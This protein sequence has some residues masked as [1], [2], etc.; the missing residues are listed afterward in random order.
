MSEMTR[1]EQKKENCWAIEDLYA[2]DADWEK[3]Y[4]QLSGQM[5]NFESYK[6]E[7]GKQWGNVA[8]SFSGDGYFEM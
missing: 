6:G 8:G 7:T 2:T 3:D 5:K 4:S 1:Q